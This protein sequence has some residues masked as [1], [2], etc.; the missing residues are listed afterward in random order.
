M[1]ENSIQLR[2][3]YLFAISN[4]IFIYAYPSLSHTLAL[5]LSHASYIDVIEIRMKLIRDFSHKFNSNFF[6][7]SNKERNFQ[8]SIYFY[9][10]ICV[11][12][13]KIYVFAKMQS[14]MTLTILINI[15][16][17]INQLKLLCSA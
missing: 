12:D 10:T 5:S 17:S 11:M 16:E 15:F 6:Y 13:T 9:A 8:N 2:D 3:F 4:N 7:F 14:T 1:E